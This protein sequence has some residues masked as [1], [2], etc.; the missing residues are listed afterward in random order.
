MGLVEMKGFF[1]VDNNCQA[2]DC[3][4]KRNSP[5]LKP[6]KMLHNTHNLYSYVLDSMEQQVE[7]YEKIIPLLLTKCILGPTQVPL[8]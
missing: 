1:Y 5:F 2:L 7:V 6:K 3:A 8:N 4:Q